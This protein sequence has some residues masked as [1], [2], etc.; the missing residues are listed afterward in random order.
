METRS[1]SSVE[2]VY[3]E[4]D[5][6]KKAP[7]VPKKNDIV[8]DSQYSAGDYED[9][10]SLQQIFDALEQNEK[11]LKKLSRANASLLHRYRQ[12][13]F[14]NKKNFKKCQSRCRPSYPISVYNGSGYS[15]V[16]QCSVCKSFYLNELVPDMWDENQQYRDV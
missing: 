7:S 4:L 6:K 8:K 12:L 9:Y 15:N 11:D 1:K 13:Y 10:C 3:Y 2:T 14:H 16:N 5:I